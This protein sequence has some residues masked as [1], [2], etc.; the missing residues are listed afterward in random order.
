MPINNDVGFSPCC[1]FEGV[2]A[3][4]ARLV[5]A[6]H[7]PPLNALL[8]ELMSARQLS[9]HREAQSLEADR[10]LII[11]WLADEH[12]LGL[13]LQHLLRLNERLSVEGLIIG[14]IRLVY[15][16]KGRGPRVQPRG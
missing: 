11:G 10:T 7:Q 3:V 2:V 14:S 5:L 12:R 15:G 9:R 4:R 8:V 6:L 16:H 13:V 1:S